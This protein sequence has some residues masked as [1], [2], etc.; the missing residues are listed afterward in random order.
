MELK[1]QIIKKV[2][3][4][5]SGADEYEITE[6]WQE[7]RVRT[8]AIDNLENRKASLQAQIDEIDTKVSDMQKL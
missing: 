3:N 2:V 6:V 8:E 4:T 5:D 1:S 7:T